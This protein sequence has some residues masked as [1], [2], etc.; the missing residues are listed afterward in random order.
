MGGKVKT[1]YLSCTPLDPP[2]RKKKIDLLGNLKG[3]VSMGVTAALGKLGPPGGKKYP[4]SSYD[5]H[6][7]AKQEGNKQ[8]RALYDKHQMDDTDPD[9]FEASFNRLPPEVRAEVLATRAAVFAS[10]GKTP[11][12]SE[13]QAAKATAPSAPA[14]ALDMTDPSEAPAPDAAP[15]TAPDT[16]DSSAGE[17]KDGGYVGD[18]PAIGE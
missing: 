13:Q 17:G 11:N 5:L 7:R 8:L 2:V 12:L 10:V 6:H 9:K 4:S 14:P 15:D 18:N 3:A 16:G 1:R